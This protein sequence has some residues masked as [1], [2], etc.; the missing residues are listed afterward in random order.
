MRYKMRVRRGAAQYDA[1]LT[2]E[3]WTTDPPEWAEAMNAAFPIRSTAAG[4]PV[5]VCFEEAAAT[6]G[7]EVLLRDDPPPRPNRIY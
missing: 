1:I 5:A 4:N 2:E 7:A 6:T 3:G